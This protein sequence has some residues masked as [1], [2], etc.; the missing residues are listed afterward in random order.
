MFGIDNFVSNSFHL[1]SNESYYLQTTN[2]LTTINEEYTTAV[3]DLYKSVVENKDNDVVLNESFSSFLDKLYSVIKKIVE[4]IK[5]LFEACLKFIAD[6]VNINAYF[7]SRAKTLKTKFYDEQE[8]EYDGYEYRSDLYTTKSSQVKLTYHMET[9]TNLLVKGLDRGFIESAKQ[10]TSPK[11]LAVIINK[12]SNNLRDF[13]DYTYYDHIRG[14]IL[15]SYNYQTIVRDDFKQECDNYFRCGDSGIQT[16]VINP[17][18]ILKYIGFI[19][20]YNTIKQAIKQEQKDFERLMNNT[21]DSVKSYA[22]T[23]I[24]ENFY[25][26]PKVAIT[27]DVRTQFDIY[28]KRISVAMQE[29]LNIYALYIASKLDAAKEL[30]NQSVDI[31]REAL[32]RC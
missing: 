4:F 28:T 17:K 32:M 26:N 10:A 29:T 13:L 2:Y 6:Q 23:L 12:Y 5:S 24:Q 15:D 1:N 27:E 8:F 16:L 9:L 30:Y 18:T 19:D 3:K 21:I 14:E 25:T 31:C 20:D 11:Q 7:K 22:T